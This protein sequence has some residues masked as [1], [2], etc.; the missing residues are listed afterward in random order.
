MKQNDNYMLHELNGV[1]YLLP[2]GQGVADLRRGVRINRTG[3]YIWDLLDTE[4]TEEQILSLCAAHFHAADEELPQLQAD[5][6]QFL[7][8]LRLWGLLQ[9]GSCP[10]APAAGDRY[11]SIGGLTL[12]FT[13]PEKYFSADFSA[14]CIPAVSPDAIDQRFELRPF[15]PGSHPLG[16]ILLRNSQLLVLENEVG[17][18]LVFPAAESPLEIRLSSDGSQ[19]LIFAGGEPTELFVKDIFHAIRLCYLFLAQRKGL[20]ALHSASLLYRDH[21]W[22]F[23]G[24]SGAGKST[25]TNLWK[26]LLQVPLVNG[27]LNLLELSAAQSPRVH[28]L[29]WCGTSEISTPGLW[30][31]G[32]IVFL[33]QAP[34]DTVEQL[35]E[36]E[37]QL[38]V[39][40]HLISP[41]WTREQAALNLHGA[42]TASRRLLI[43]RLCC[44]KESTAVDTVRAVMDQWLD[45]LT[46]TASSAP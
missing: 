31:L 20:F 30:P 15:A 43:C 5:I 12:S 29:P 6:L 10:A 44:T 2:F 25:H 4:I 24:H 45:G 35:P 37:K 36:E 17:Y 23:S 18:I 9:E 3:A 13:G 40:Q 1:P 38:L 39:A 26:R 11:L 41:V 8:S 46:S 32:G 42:E 19:V 16:R 7:N 21:I 33:R 34:S 14:F 27:D 22:L 28:G